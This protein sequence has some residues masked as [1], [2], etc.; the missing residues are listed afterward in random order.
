MESELILTFLRDLR[1][2]LSDGLAHLSDLSAQP[3]SSDQ[4]DNSDQPDKSDLQSE[5]PEQ[6]EQPDLPPDF[7]ACLRN[8]LNSLE[9]YRI[10]RRPLP[11]E[12]QEA[13]GLL[14]A[15]VSDLAEGV[16]SPASAETLLRAVS[17]DRAVETA[18]REGEIA[19]RNV[20]IEEQLRSP[21]AGDGLPSL[22]GSRSA[23]PRRRRSDS[24][25]DL[26][27]QAR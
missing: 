20:R 2:H 26:A 15:M 19:G 27:E 11:D 3:N 24:I 4:S 18:R 5:Q 14:F 22:Q 21:I 7:A 23:T 10:G 8:S 13:F 12:W 9:G 6:P 16:I 1:N 17:F 25:F